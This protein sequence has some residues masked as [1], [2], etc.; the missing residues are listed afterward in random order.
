MRLQMGEHPW[1]CAYP[2]CL[3]D[4]GREAY[5][6]RPAGLYKDLVKHQRERLLFINYSIK[7]QYT[8]G[9]GKG[10][11]LPPFVGVRPENTIRGLGVFEPSVLFESLV[12]TKCF[13]GNYK[14]SL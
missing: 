4:Q 7:C 6:Q 9:G 8:I 2:A 11:S 3:M 14:N 12:N 1:G 5:M 13:E 10:D